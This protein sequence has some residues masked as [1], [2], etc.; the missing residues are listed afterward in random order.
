MSG[1]PIRRARSECSS[2]VCSSCVFTRSSGLSLPGIGQ[3]L[4]VSRTEKLGR[5]RKQDS[6]A[7]V[8]RHS[9]QTI[10]PVRTHRRRVH[11]VGTTG[12]LG[13]RGP[14]SRVGLPHRGITTRRAMPAKMATTTPYRWRRPQLG[15]TAASSVASEARLGFS[16]QGAHG[17]I[18]CKS[19]SPIPRFGTR[20]VGRS[21]GGGS[22][23]IGGITTIAS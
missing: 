7:R 13:R 16:A 10:A 12:C 15:P 18:T 11:L 17:A 23:W 22:T 2:T 14:R 6:G 8:S 5:R 9:E 4:R 20:T 1:S 3:S 21:G 19:R